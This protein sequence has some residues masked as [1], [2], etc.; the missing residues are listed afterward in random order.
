MTVN[1]DKAIV[2]LIN[3]KPIFT[4]IKLLI[5]KMKIPENNYF[6]RN[7]AADTKIFVQ[8][9]IPKFLLP[10]HHF[11]QMEEKTITT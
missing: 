6:I 2:N 8:N 4:L 1:R 9:I 3:N 7:V 11:L 10:I 5:C